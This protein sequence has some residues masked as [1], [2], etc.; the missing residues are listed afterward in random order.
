MADSWLDHIP[1]H[2]RQRLRRRM[3]SEAEYQKLRERVKGP[4]DLEKEMS[5]NEAV[6]ELRFEME[7]QPEVKNALKKQVEKDLREQGMESVVESES[8]S[9]EQK[10]ALE[11]GKF[12]VAVSAHPATH[13]DH[14]MVQPEGNVQEKIPLKP[15]FNDRYVSQFVQAATP[16]GKLACKKSS[17]KA[18]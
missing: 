11:A 4:E 9:P 15:A 5:R 10:K 1:S 17:R 6:A 12:A 3:R 13:Q 7:T 14:L 18:A 16:L 8:L 2:E